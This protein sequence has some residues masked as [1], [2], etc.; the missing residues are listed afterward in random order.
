[1]PKLKIPHVHTG[2]RQ[3][4]THG[5]EFARVFVLGIRRD[6]TGAEEMLQ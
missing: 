4:A 1:M 6:P 5:T 2:G 3:G